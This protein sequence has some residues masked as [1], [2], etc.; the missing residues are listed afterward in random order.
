MVLTVERL[1]LQVSPRNVACFFDRV[2]LPR[3]A[4]I[5]FSIEP[6]GAATTALAFVALIS[7]S[8]CTLKNLTIRGSFVEG[9][10]RPITLYLFSC[11]KLT[12][13][14]L[15]ELADPNALDPL[16]RK[17]GHTLVLPEGHTPLPLEGRTLPVLLPDLKDLH[18]EVTKSLA[19]SMDKLGPLWKSWS[20]RQP[21]M[22]R[23]HV[24][25]PLPRDR[26]LHDVTEAREAWGDVASQVS[27]AVE[28]S[29]ADTSK[30][31]KVILSM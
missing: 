16:I 21:S 24:E 13:L 31:S 27:I 19:T 25:V 8:K 30:S 7:R 15:A 4:S 2:T 12:E 9:N 5:G 11:P 28:K 10:P 23:L 14:R 6:S 29:S 3:L 20:L 17:L 18:I 22:C 1:Q 26:E